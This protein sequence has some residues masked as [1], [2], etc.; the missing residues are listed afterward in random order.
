MGKVLAII[1]V[2]LI[3]ACSPIDY[4]PSSENDQQAF[5]TWEENQAQLPWHKRTIA[6]GKSTKTVDDF[7]FE[8]LERRVDKLERTPH[9]Q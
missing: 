2:A 8:A 9:H 5:L 6:K 3:C 1:S 4:H 7:R